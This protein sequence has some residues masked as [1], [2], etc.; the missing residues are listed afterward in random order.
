MKVAPI[1][2]NFSNFYGELGQLSLPTYQLYTEQEHHSEMNVKWQLIPVPALSPAASELIK[3]H[4]H[5]K[6]Q[7]EFN[8]TVMN[9]P[10]CCN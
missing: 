8:Y 7:L 5:M 4:F 3:Y 2:A 9:C 6:H 1:L 10:Q